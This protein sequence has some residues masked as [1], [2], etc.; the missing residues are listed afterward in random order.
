MG[1]DRDKRWLRKYA[2]LHNWLDVNAS[3][4][5]KIMSP[6]ETALLHFGGTVQGDSL[7]L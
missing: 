5:R 7:E 4:A 2:C 6:N 3:E 1:L